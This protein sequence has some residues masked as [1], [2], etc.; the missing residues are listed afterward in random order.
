MVKNFFTENVYVNA[1]ARKVDPFPENRNSAKGGG[2]LRRS[3][4][5]K[6]IGKGQ[7]PLFLGEGIF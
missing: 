5:R 2:S 4:K 3:E 1:T 6:E 7:N